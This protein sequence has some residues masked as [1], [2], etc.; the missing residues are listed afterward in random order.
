MLFQQAAAVENVAKPRNPKVPDRL[1]NEPKT[2]E[3]F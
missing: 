3:R 1:A 2:S